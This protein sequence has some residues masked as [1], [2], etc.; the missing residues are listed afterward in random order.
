MG[1]LSALPH[2]K[3]DGSTPAKVFKGWKLKLPPG[4]QATLHKTHPLRRVTTRRHYAGWQAEREPPRRKVTL[5]LCRD[6]N[7]H[8]A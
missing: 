3:A 6:Q 8:G 5:T 4:Q 2:V 1:S 7:V